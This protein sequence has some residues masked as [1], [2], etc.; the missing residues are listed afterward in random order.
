MYTPT[1]AVRD[2]WKLFARYCLL[3]RQ[4]ATHKNNSQAIFVENGVELKKELTCRLFAA[5][6]GLE[7]LKEMNVSAAS[8]VCLE[9]SLQVLWKVEEAKERL[10]GGD[11]VCRRSAEE[12]GGAS[13]QHQGDHTLDRARL[14]G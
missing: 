4:V 13:D 2:L 9:L 11:P 1:G 3:N 8:G 5:K 12:P 14:P 7:L 6:S 10:A